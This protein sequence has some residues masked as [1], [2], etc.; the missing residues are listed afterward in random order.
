MSQE[1][2][3]SPWASQPG[4]VLQV[5]T[6]SLCPPA[7]FTPDYAREYEITAYVDVQGRTERL[8]VV[9]KAKGLVR[10]GMLGAGQGTGPIMGL[11]LGVGV[12]LERMH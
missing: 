11:A 1:Q 9:F 6:F 8:P 5:L 7:Q 12:E 3:S 4:A 2:G 10:G